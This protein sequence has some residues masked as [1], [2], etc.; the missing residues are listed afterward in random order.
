MSCTKQQDCPRYEGH[1][2][3]CGFAA[4]SCE[5]DL[6]DAEVV[7]PVVLPPVSNIF[8]DVQAWAE[9]TSPAYRLGMQFRLE[10]AAMV[11]KPIERA[12]LDVRHERDRQDQLKAS[13]RFR[14]TCADVGLGDGDRM[15]VLC[16]EVG[17]V[18]RALLERHGAVNDQHGV[19][20]RK[21]LVQVAAV[22][23]AWIELLDSEAKK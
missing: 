15:A 12:L 20:L 17:E 4:S 9:Q 19:D 7:P 14:Y 1:H 8:R 21:E 11:E 3:L 2:G 6:S 16:E 22:A 5:L 23:C 10:G 18:A 13:G